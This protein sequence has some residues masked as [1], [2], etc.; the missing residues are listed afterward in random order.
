VDRYHCIIPM[1]ECPKC[2]RSMPYLNIAQIVG[3]YFSE[4]DEQIKQEKENQKLFLCPL[5]NEIVAR[6][7]ETADKL[8]TYE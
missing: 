4:G 1:N 5:C 7:H 6:D 3:K 2:K 8:L